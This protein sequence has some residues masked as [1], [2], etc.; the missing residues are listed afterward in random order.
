MGGARRC[1]APQL[2]LMNPTE[3]AC[4]RLNQS[5]SIGITRSLIPIGPRHQQFHELAASQF[6]LPQWSVLLGN[7]SPDPDLHPIADHPSHHRILGRLEGIGRH[8]AE[9]S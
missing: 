5:P 7:A 1:L 2:S 8:N 3:L 6:D 9:T 4:R